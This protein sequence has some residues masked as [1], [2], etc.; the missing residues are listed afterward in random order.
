MKFGKI[1]PDA[2]T[3]AIENQLAMAKA[4]LRQRFHTENM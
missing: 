3:G 1:Y 2:A 4:L